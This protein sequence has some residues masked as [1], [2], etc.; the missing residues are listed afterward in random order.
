MSGQLGTD[1][2]DQTRLAS[3]DFPR[4]ICTLSVVFSGAEQVSVLFLRQPG[5][6]LIDLAFKHQYYTREAQVSRSEHAPAYYVS[7]YSGLCF[8]C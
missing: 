1:S 3:A 4:A 8:C 7:L 5:S 2:P 6:L